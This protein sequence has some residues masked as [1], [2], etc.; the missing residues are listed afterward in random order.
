MNPQFKT[1]I[2]AWQNS[3][4]FGNLPLPSTQP[5]RLFV[6]R[7]NRIHTDHLTFGESRKAEQVIFMFEPS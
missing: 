2:Y 7:T 5:L 1:E 4:I 3:F 6:P